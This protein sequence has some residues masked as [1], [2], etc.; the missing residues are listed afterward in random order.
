MTDVVL[1]A[2]PILERF[3]LDGR[4]AVVTGAGQGIGRAFAHELGEG[5]AAVAVADVNLKTAEGVVSEL[6][7]KKID[8]IAV[9]VDVTKADQAQKMIDAVLAKWGK[10]T[11][12]V[13]N[14]GIGQWVDTE[15]MA[16]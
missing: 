9:Q 7:A 15:K 5:G 3:R 4:V 1:T 14:A 2:K 10:L 13:N 11:I 12:G 8:S 16:E 6:A